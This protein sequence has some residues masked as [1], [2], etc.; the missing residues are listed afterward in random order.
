MKK[1]KLTRSL[2]AAVS[3]VALSAVMYGC[4]HNGGDDPEPMVEP[5][6]EPMP[7]PEPDSGEVDLAA[8]QEA[9]ADAAAAAMTAST[10]AA[11]S[12]ASAIAATANLATSQTGA[13]AAGYAMKASDAADMAMAAYMDAKAASDEAAAATM[14]SA[15]GAALANAEAAQMAAENA[16]E[17]AASYAMKA[18]DA[19]MMEL[20]IDGTMKSVGD[21]TIDAA[22]GAST[23]TTGT[24]DDAQTVITGLL[25]KAL[26]PMATGGAITGN[27]YTPATVDNLNTAID[28]TEADDAVAKTMP[29]KQ[30][31]A[32]R[33]FPVGKALDS[34]DDM[35]RLMIVTHYAGENMVKVFAPGDATADAVTGTKAGYLTIDDGDTETT[36]TNNTPLRSLGMFYPT[37]PATAGTLVSG[38]SIAAGAKPVEVFSYIDPSVTVSGT[39]DGVRYAT[40]RSDGTD[41]ATGV[42]TYSYTTGAGIIAAMAAPDGPDAGIEPDAARVIVPIPGPVA[43]QHIHFG[44]WA[45]L[46]MAEKDGSQEVA[47]HGIGFVQ[48]IGDGMTGADMPNAGEAKYSGNWAATV[49]TAAGAVSLE[50][51]AAS[52]TANL[53]KSTLMA[54][55]TGLAMLEGA[56]DGS[57]FS[58]TKATVGTNDHGLTPG[59]KFTGSFNGGFYGAAAAEA[60]GI[61][62][63]TSDASGAFRGAFG[64]AKDE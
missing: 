63:F 37:T 61:F 59:G 38:D 46:G 54:T 28:E 20:M 48:S 10:E 30:T 44:V 45:D 8:T 26:H 33:T 47:G 4:V 36:D 22:S 12:S 6:P 42:T 17:M 32:A 23:T 62:D 56:L 40:L 13:M 19:A 27:V 9:A 3:I 25:D 49:E 57:A 15:A 64:G 51:G 1:T 5:M 24:G 7:E 43:Y 53:D 34:S 58:G 31:A 29:Y 2:M 18:S 50:H 21:T 60:G 39:E 35:A 11:A 14:A 52:L 41:A 55:L 16:A